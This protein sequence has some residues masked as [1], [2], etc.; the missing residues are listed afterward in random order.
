MNTQGLINSSFPLLFNGFHSFLMLLQLLGAARC[1]AQLGRW[2]WREDVGS[3]G[4]KYVL[5]LVYLCAYGSIKV[6]KNKSCEGKC[7]QALHQW[8]VFITKYC[9]FSNVTA[10]KHC[11]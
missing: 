1:G 5:A 2:M 7:H 4:C 11:W 3:K 6:F 8:H 9:I 10:L